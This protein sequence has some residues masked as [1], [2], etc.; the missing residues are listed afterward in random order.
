MK[1]IAAISA[2][3]FIAL[4]SMFGTNASPAQ[5]ELVPTALSILLFVAGTALILGI[6]FGHSALGSA[7]VFGGLAL[8][9]VWLPQQYYA[10]E[11]SLSH[12]AITLVLTIFTLALGFFV[13]GLV[14]LRIAMQLR[15]AD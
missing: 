11:E 4:A 7:T 14:R 8:L 15:Q 1:V 12:S 3:L 13:G 10:T 2:F 5:T 6:V 9:F